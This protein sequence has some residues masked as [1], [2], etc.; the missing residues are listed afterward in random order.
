MLKTLYGA[1]N[2]KCMK[3][4]VSVRYRES[5]SESRKIL[6]VEDSIGLTHINNVCLVVNE[7]NHTHSTTYDERD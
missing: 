5:P 3:E 4:K 1:L 6:E 7:L 2:E